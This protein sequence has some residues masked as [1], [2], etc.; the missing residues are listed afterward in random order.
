MLT[1]GSALGRN[2]ENIRSARNWLVIVRRL[3]LA[4]RSRVCALTFSRSH[5]W[6]IAVKSSRSALRYST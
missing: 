1:L 4:I 5:G 6:P 2:R 3:I